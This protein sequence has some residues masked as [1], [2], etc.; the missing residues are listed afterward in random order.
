MLP[1][2]WNLQAQD[3]I[4]DIFTYISVR[5]RAAAQRLAEEIEASTLI[6]SEHPNL[7]KMSRRIAGCREFVVHTNYI[8][9]YRVEAD[10]VRVVRVVHGSRMYF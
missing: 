8:V 7:Y 2:I 4:D 9:I 3:D 5:N 6:L 10:C 1:V